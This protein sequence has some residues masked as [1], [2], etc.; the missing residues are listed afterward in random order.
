[1][2]QAKLAYGAGKRCS[3]PTEGV[4]GLMQPNCQQQ[5]MGRDDYGCLHTRGKEIMCGGKGGMHLDTLPEECWCIV[6]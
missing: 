2:P 6:G 3:L 5:G 1:M 4:D